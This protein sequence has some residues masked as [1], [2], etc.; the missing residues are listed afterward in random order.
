MPH[1]ALHQQRGE[2][3]IQVDKADRKKLGF[4]DPSKGREFNFRGQESPQKPGRPHLGEDMERRK[5]GIRR[6]N[7][8][9]G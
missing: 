3:A 7:L 5:N 1:V 8:R 4:A 6:A 9:N 2:I